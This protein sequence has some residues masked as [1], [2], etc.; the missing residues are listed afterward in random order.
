MKPYKDNEMLYCGHVC[1]QNME[2]HRT[3]IKYYTYSALVSIT[4]SKPA[5]EPGKGNP[6]HPVLTCFIDYP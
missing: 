6:G 4:L 3:I 1:K 5:L 2:Y